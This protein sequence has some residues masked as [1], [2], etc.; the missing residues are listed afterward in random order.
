MFT[1]SWVH[2]SLLAY[3]VYPLSTCQ[4]S[5]QHRGPHRVSTGSTQGKHCMPVV[6]V[7]LFAYA[8]YPVSTCLIINIIMK[9]KKKNCKP[10]L[11]KEAA[12][13]KSPKLNASR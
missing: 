7:S 2:A 1:M 9:E 8:L 13:I 3:S 10:T 11:Y 6:H 4:H 5:D 12:K